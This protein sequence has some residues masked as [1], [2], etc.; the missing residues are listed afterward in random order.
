MSIQCEHIL[1][2]PGAL[3]VNLNIYRVLPVIYSHCLLIYRNPGLPH[4]SDPED[5]TSAYIPDYKT[6]F[7]PKYVATSAIKRLS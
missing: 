3:V 5:R 2:A 7:S 6:S 4:K 1:D